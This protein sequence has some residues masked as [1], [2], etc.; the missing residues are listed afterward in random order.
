MVERKTKHVVKRGKLFFVSSFI[1]SLA[2]MLFSLPHFFLDEY[3]PLESND[4][5]VTDTNSTTN[6][7]SYWVIFL[8]AM[9]LISAIAY[10]PIYT[11]GKL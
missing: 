7:S 1:M 6:D 9:S 5:N 10:L 4:S 2:I 11:T 8:V 3:L